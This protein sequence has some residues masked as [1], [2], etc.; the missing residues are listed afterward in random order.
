M[1][2]P[3]V[4]LASLY[5]DSGE[6]SKAASSFQRGLDILRDAHGAEHPD[7][8]MPLVGLAE[9][10]LARRHPQDAVTYARDALALQEKAGGRDDDAA[11]TRFLLARALW[12]VGNERAR[13]LA[14][15]TEARGI[16]RRMG[17]AHP[18]VDDIDA[19]LEVHSG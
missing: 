12:A 13:A 10:A 2:A 6:L 17:S 5:V 14:L 15:A 19:W 4:G 9:V 3:L 1:A 7:V 8:A 18:V 16:L 11:R